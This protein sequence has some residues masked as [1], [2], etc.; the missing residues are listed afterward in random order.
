MLTDIDKEFDTPENDENGELIE[1]IEED[2]IFVEEDT[3][4]EEQDDL[5]YEVEDDIVQ[6]GEDEEEFDNIQEVTVEAKENYDNAKEQLVAIFTSILEKGEITAE[7]NVEIE[8]VKEQYSE[9]YNSIKE[10]TEN[11]QKKTLEE[12][13]EELKDGMVGATTDEILNILTDD[14]RKP[15]LYKNEDND[16]LVDM[17]AIPELT[18][19]V[20]KLNLIATDGENE[21]EFQLTKDFIKMIV[22]GTGSGNAVDSIVNKYYVSIS[23]TELIEGTWV[24]D[25]PDPTEQ[26]GKFLWIKT[27]TT[28]LDQN[29]KPQE[30]TPICISAQDG[31]DGTNGK[32]SYFHIK[33]SPVPNPTASQMT[34]TPN[35]YI[36]TYVDFTEADST[37]PSKYKWSRFEGLQGSKGEQG[38][39]GTNGANGKT[40]YLHIKYSNDGG[41]TFTANNGETVGDYIG[42]CTDFNINDP[43]TVSAY[44]WVKIKGEQGQPGIQGIQGERGQQGIPGTNGANGQTS[45]FHIKYSPV[46]NPTASQMTETPNTYIGTYVDFTEADSTDPSKYKWSRFEGLQGSKGEQGIPGTNGANGKTTYLHI[47]Y[48]NDEGKTFTANNGETVGDYIGTCTDF[49]INDPTT[50]SVYTW[51]KVKGDKGDQGIPGQNGV[52]VEEVIIQYSKGTSTSTAPTS[53]WSPSMPNY[54]E[55]YYL[56]VRTR[57]KYSNRTDYVYSTATCDQSWK[58]TQETYT[59]FEQLRDKINLIA[60]DNEDN[61]SIVLTPLLIQLI[62]SSDIELS[63][64]Q[65][66]ITGDT[67][68][69]GLVT[70]NDYFVINKDGSISC[71]KASISGAIT[72]TGNIV[73]YDNAKGFR[74]RDTDEVEITLAHVGTDNCS[75][76]GWGSWSKASQKAYDMGCEYLG[77]K[78][79]IIRSQEQT[80]LV[81]NGGTYD[82]VGGSAIV[83]LMNSAGDYALRPVAPNKDYL[84][85][86]TYYWAGVSSKEF[87]NT[88][89]RNLKENVKYLSNAENIDINSNISALD[90]YDFMK[91]DLPVA[92]YNYIDDFRMKI[93]VIA[94]DIVYNAD[95]SNNKVG[96]LIV[97]MI[98]YEENN[99]G[100][101]LTYDMNNFIG[102]IA[103]AQQVNIKKTEG[104][105]ERLNK[106]EKRLELLEGA[107]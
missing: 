95:N 101:K 79:A 19:L 44:T 29:K 6:E 85:T 43:T 1:V 40:T 66:K 57:V 20:N 87:N 64:K 27:V 26:E 11:V 45:Y 32:T 37:D 33:Y 106:I 52:S 23:K 70:A 71:K 10:N 67:I 4:L 3:G 82:S 59:L 89:D 18:V 105:D 35:T 15:W 100:A 24:D 55:G 92:L 107:K 41:K 8:Q 61:S 25:I 34:E 16:V 91:N 83:F 17:T 51:T 77:G 99:V 21:G 93:G 98:P 7:D 73:L 42:T 60:I 62:S 39:P 58:A 76:F 48:S 30:T 9:A 46:V 65:V 13:L 36:G 90:C 12:Q 56:W 5:F 31:S 50:V 2:D 102:V 96:Q 104:H 80:Y 86:G 75:R 81:C 54:Q 78:R 74:G 72:A 84:G 88:S 68:I 49:N 69:D 63:G 47:K 94:Q 28:F 22:G 53:G 97:N 103:A 38:I 14:G